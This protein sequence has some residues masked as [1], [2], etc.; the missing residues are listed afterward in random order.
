M[1]E[2]LLLNK[3]IKNIGLSVYFKNN[4]LDYEYQLVYKLLNLTNYEMDLN[5]SNNIYFLSND[6]NL[7]LNYLKCFIH[8]FDHY[9]FNFQHFDIIFLFNFNHSFKRNREEINLDVKLNIYSIY[10]EKSLIFC[11]YD[12]N[13]FVFGLVIFYFLINQ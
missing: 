10:Y 3:N 8:Q 5:F 4:I 11:S 2:S 12:I 9:F 1:K 7:K 13:I 6:I